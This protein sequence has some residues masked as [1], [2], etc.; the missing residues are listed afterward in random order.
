MKR[1]LVGLML[2]LLLTGCGR[3]ETYTV[4]GLT[5]RLQDNDPGM[6]YT[7]AKTLGSYGVEAK[8]AVPQ[9]TQAL[10][11]TDPSVRVGAAYALAAIGPDAE[12]ALSALTDALKDPD[13]ELRVAAAYAIPAV[14]PAAQTALPTLQQLAQRDRER[15]VR[16]GATQAIR[17][18]EAAAKYRPSPALS[19]QK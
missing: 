17:K 2:L 6:R 7:A 10:K 5:Q 18:L 3:D 9:L 11:D 19:A 4:P 16:E 12:S 13:A 8:P 15:R 14:G 1:V